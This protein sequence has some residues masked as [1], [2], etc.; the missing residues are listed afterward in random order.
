VV[1]NKTSIYKKVFFYNNSKNTDRKSDKQISSELNQN[2]EDLKEWV[3]K[4]I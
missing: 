4:L 3:N 1:D 2:Y